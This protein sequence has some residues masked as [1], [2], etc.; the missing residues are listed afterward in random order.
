MSTTSR[1]VLDKRPYNKGEEIQ[2]KPRHEEKYNSK[3]V[4]TSVYQYLE[5]SNGIQ[6]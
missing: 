2:G 6:K 3:M 1:F 4:Q 5:G